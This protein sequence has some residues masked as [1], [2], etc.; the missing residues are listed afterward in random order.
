MIEKGGADLVHIDVMDGRF[1]PN[2]TIGPVV[3]SS[4]RELTKL[5]LDVHLMIEDPDRYISEFVEAGADILVA[6]SS[7][8]GEADPLEAIRAIREAAI[9]G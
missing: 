6:G 5:S 8:F 3:V 7:V 4:I 1:V 9:L 2:I